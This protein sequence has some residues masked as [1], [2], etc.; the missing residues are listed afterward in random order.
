[1]TIKAIMQK[2]FIDFI[3]KPLK[4]HQQVSMSDIE[5][6][7]DGDRIPVVLNFGYAFDGEYVLER[8]KGTLYFFRD[9][10]FGKY[11]IYSKK[12][13]EEIITEKKFREGKFSASGAVFHTE[14]FPRFFAKR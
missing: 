6:M 11:I 7:S 8:R 10:Y 1:M 3:Y 5:M 9:G 4:L 2:D 13:I 12:G 14:K